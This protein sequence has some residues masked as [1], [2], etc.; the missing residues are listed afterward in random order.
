MNGCQIDMRDSFERDLRKL[1]ETTKKRIQ[2]TLERLKED[3]YLGKPLKGRLKGLRRCR[4][5]KYRVLYYPQPCR[6]ILI[7][8]RPRDS[9]YI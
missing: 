9:V 1:D 5:G 2:E 7:K 8:V 4:V 3:P 6:V